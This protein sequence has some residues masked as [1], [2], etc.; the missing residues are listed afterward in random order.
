MYSTV[1]TSKRLKNFKLGK[2]DVSFKVKQCKNTKKDKKEY[3]T[4]K[5]PGLAT[6]LRHSLRDDLRISPKEEQ[7][8]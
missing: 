5:Y 4:V 8:P 2:N 3:S 6:H 7:D 1:L